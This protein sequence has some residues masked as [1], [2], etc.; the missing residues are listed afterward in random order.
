[1]IEIRKIAKT[2]I[3]KSEENAALRGVDLT[4]D[5]GDIFGI[6][7]K[8]GAGKTTLLRILAQ[9]ER[10]TSGTVLVNGAQVASPGILLNDRSIKKR[11]GIVFQNYDLLNQETVAENVAFPLRIRGIHKDV[12][13]AKVKELLSLVGLSEKFAAYPAQLSGGQ[14]QRIAIARALATDPDLLLLDEPTSALDSVAT[15]AILDLLQKINGERHVTIL[16]ITHEIGVVRRICQR[17]AVID[18][19]KIVEEGRVEEVFEM[20]KSP[21]T[22]LLIGFKGA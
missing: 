18:E 15:K 21:I 9:L 4:I 10:P 16:I 8:S 13:M 7:G 11:I 6:I 17:V 1:M 5:D 2:Y 12:R 22:K 19:G 20:P 14:K 3:A